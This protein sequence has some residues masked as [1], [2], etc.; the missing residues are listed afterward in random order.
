M[1]N[2]RHISFV[3]VQPA[4]RPPRRAGFHPSASL[5]TPPLSAPLAELDPFLRWLL[6]RAGLDARAYRARALNRR[7]GACLRRL[8]AG[9]GEEARALLERRPYLLSRAVDAVLIG[10]T[11]FF[12]DKPVFD[13][14]ERTALPD[15]VL[16]RGPPRV[17]AAGVSDGQELY[18]LAILL[19]EAGALD[20]ARLLGVDCRPDAVARARRGRFAAEQ[21]AGLSPERRARWF[22]AEGGVF[23]ARPA[24]GARIAWRTG[25]LFADDDGAVF[26]IVLFRNVAIY[27]EAAAAAR[28]WRSLAGRLAPGGLLVTGKAERPPES[29]GLTRLAPSVFKKEEAPC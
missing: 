13:F 29:L 23:A 20:G 6:G 7:L 1:N 22:A 10:V 16:R 15:L 8:R 17:F 28:A 18:S 25:D 3:G 4:P 5:R 2:L 11:D 19:G 26:D 12:R 21:L 24:L 14:L 9:S 27:L